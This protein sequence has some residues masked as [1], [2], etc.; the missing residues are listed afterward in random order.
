MLAMWW[1]QL[2]VG[3]CCEWE[4]LKSHWST[5][6]HWSKAVLKH[7]TGQRGRAHAPTVDLKIMCGTQKHAEQAWP[8][9]CMANAT[10]TVC[11]RYALA[12][13]NFNRRDWRIIRDSMTKFMLCFCCGT[14]KEFACENIRW[15]IGTLHVAMETCKNVFVLFS[16]MFLF[17]SD[18]NLHIDWTFCALFKF[19]NMTFSVANQF[20]M[21]I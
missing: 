18:P 8:L 16:Y 1:P 5:S 2:N 13:C 4:T 10:K 21:W 15:E 19:C 11:V 3:Y 12:I 6:A 9:K 14:K 20:H 17:L 7:C